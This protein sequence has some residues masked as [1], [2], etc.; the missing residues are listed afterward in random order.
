[1]TRAARVGLYLVAAVVAVVVGLAV[2]SRSSTQALDPTAERALTSVG[3]RDLEGNA[4]RLDRWAGKTVVVNFWATWCAPCRE[5]I[6]GLITVHRE[7]ESKQALVVGVAIDGSSK[8]AA[9]AREYAIPY[10]V[11]VGGAPV[12]DVLRV[13]GNPGGALPYTVIVAPD[14][15]IVARHLGLLHPADLRRMLRNVAS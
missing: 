14:G 6:P 5:E 13:V 2:G 9:F 4:V 7:I 8:V 1:M 11:L 12:L 15:R 10:P 3:L